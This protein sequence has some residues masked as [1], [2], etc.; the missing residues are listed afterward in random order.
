MLIYTI[1]NNLAPNPLLM[2]E[3]SYRGRVRVGKPFLF[4][5]GY[6]RGESA[7]FSFLRGPVFYFLALAPQEG[8]CVTHA[9]HSVPLPAEGPILHHI[10]QI[11][12][13]SMP[14][15]APLMAII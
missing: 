11:R 4:I 8:P 5:F 3:W 2:G 15:L 1:C 9:V 6:E 7:F 12:F 13:Q 14:L 10:R